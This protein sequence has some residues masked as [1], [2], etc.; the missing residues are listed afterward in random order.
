MSQRGKTDV[1][2]HEHVWNLGCE[3]MSICAYLYYFILFP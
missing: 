3:N 2:Q 1:A